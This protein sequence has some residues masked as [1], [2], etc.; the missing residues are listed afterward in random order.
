MNPPLILID[1]SV[2]INA[3]SKKADEKLKMIF[4]TL[5]LEQRVATTP[6]IKMELLGGT[7]DKKEFFHLSEEL[8]ALHQ[9]DFTPK[10]WNYASELGF[11]LRRKGLKIPNTDLLLAA[12]TLIYRCPL[13]HQDKHFE[14]I[15]KHY[16]LKFY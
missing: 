12:T 15:A 10:I 4:E 9:L 2:W 8:Q 14:L 7:L 13:W 1:T 6:L 16:P 11:S 3:I 5:L